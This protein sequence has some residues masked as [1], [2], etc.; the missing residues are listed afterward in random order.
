MGLGIGTIAEV[1]KQSMGGKQKEGMHMLFS[2]LSVLCSSFLPYHL[3]YAFA[4]FQPSPGSQSF[5]FGT[6]LVNVL[7]D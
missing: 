7:I 4:Y 6:A 2:L 1:A 3:K 5:T